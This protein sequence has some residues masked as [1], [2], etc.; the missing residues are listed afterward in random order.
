M[1]MIM[2]SYEKM[3]EYYQSLPREEVERLFYEKSEK[4]RKKRLEQSKAGIPNGVGQIVVQPIEGV[5]HISDCLEEVLR[6][7]RKKPSSNTE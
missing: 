7:L 4:L 2:K 1:C 3:L 6:G 5:H